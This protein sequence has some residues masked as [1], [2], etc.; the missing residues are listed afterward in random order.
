MAISGCTGYDNA[1]IYELVSVPHCSFI[2]AL[3]CDFSKT[4]ATGLTLYGPN[5]GI[6][7][8]RSVD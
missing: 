5:T 3:I 6:K 4:K 8:D 7:Y 2:N 1:W